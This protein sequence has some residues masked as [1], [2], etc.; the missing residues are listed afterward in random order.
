MRGID[1]GKSQR[2][3]SPSNEMGSPAKKAHQCV[4]N[5]GLSRATSQ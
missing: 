3:K 4:S 2:D 1:A 5:A